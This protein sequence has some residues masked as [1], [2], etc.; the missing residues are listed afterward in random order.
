MRLAPFCL[1]GNRIEQKHSPF[2]AQ[3]PLPLKPQL[4]HKGECYGHAASLVWMQLSVSVTA[5]TPDQCSAKNTATAELTT[6]LNSPPTDFT[7]HRVKMQHK[8]GTAH[9][10]RDI[11]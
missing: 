10:W 3:I 1:A 7:N 4:K 5:V 11:S 2:L 9:I 8:C 6:G